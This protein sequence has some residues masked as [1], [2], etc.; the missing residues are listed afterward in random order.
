MYVRIQFEVVKPAGSVYTSFAVVGVSVI[1]AGL[2]EFKSS[3][4]N[5]MDNI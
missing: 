1:L 4:A 2:Y 3:Y 5:A